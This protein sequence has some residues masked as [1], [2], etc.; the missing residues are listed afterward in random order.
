MLAC[1]R[2]DLL[3]SPTFSRIVSRSPVACV[4]TKLVEGLRSHARASH[5][6]LRTKPAAASET[7]K[8]HVA[9]KGARENTTSSGAKKTLSTVFMTLKRKMSLMCEASTCAAAAADAPAGARR[10]G[11]EPAK[12][13]ASPQRPS[14]PSPCK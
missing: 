14:S 12:P 5:S 4:C 3:A 1:S 2:R 8:L 13:P 7:S 9:W 11:V 6:N 10:Q